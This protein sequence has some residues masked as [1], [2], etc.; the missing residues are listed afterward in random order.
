M[1][2]KNIKIFRKWLKLETDN[3][4]KDE[5]FVGFSY[6]YNT[7]GR[8]TTKHRGFFNV[9][10]NQAKDIET[11]L[12]TVLDM[13]QDSQAIYEFVQNAVDCN[14]T[15]YFMFYEDSHFVAINNG[16]PFTL[17][18]IRAILNFAQS[19]KTRDENI[20]KF[21]VG[22]K[23]IHRMVGSGNGLQELTK[24][25]TGPILFSWSSNEQLH[26]LL[27]ATSI[28]DIK[29]DDNDDWD[30]SDA[31]WFFKILLTCVPILPCNI[32]DNL[33]DIYYKERNDLFTE[34]EF[35]DFQSF[36]KDVWNQNQNKFAAEDLNQGSLFYLRLG[37]EKEEKLD[38]DFTFFKKGIQYSLSFVANLMAKKGLKKIYFKDE[39]PIEKDNCKR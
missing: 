9:Y 36:L 28:D 38:E 34:E 12:S 30:N 3:E 6:P 16:D 32:D 27:E 39:A 14:S 18:G 15:A 26:S 13:A 1:K 25:Y 31:P 29:P 10:H 2:V 21:G 20:G 37:A 33:R 7:D 22:F 23:L 5:N 24:D 8:T 19:T 17:E 11:R 4:N 35:Q